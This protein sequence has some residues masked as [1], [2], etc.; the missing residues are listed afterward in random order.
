MKLIDDKKEF[1]FGL[2]IILIL[3]AVFWFSV[4]I[5]GF[6]ISLMWTIVGAAIVG[7]WFRL[8]GRG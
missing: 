3:N 8:T 1:N 2:V 7:L 6:F 4:F 5:Y